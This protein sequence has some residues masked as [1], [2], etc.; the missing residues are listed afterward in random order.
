MVPQVSHK[1]LKISIWVASILGDTYRQRPSVKFKFVTDTA[2][3]NQ[4]HHRQHLALKGQ[5]V[6]PDLL[7]TVEKMVDV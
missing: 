6:D 1:K 2:N 3:A 4:S 7:V 5:N